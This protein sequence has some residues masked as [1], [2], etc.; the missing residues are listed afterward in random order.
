[1]KVS[2]TKVVCQAAF[3]N[4]Y[5]SSLQ[6]IRAYEENETVANFPDWNPRHYLDTAEQAAKVAICY[7]WLYDVWTAEQREVIETALYKHAVKT[8]KDIIYG[9]HAVT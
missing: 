6:K 2:L 9:Q 4:T 7:D 8:A 1:M 5:R 3:I